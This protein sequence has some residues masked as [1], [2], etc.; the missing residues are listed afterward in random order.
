MLRPCFFG[1]LAPFCL[2]VACDAGVSPDG[3]G[4]AGA[5][6]A[7]GSGGAS[8]TTTTASGT[9]STFGEGGSGE[10][11]GMACTGVTAAAT[12]E[13]LPVDIIWMVDNSNS[14]EPA[15]AQVKAGLNDFA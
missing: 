15:I 11:G 14:M 7:G 12:V 8:N 10:G 2:L 4:G 9:T 13:T 1:L 3:D 5:G 6:A